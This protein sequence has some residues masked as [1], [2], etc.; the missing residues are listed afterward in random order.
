MTFIDRFSRAVHSARQGV[1]NVEAYITIMTVLIILMGTAGLVLEGT[2]GVL[3]LLGFFFGAPFMTAFVGLLLHL[4]L[5]F[6][7]DSRG[8]LRRYWRSNT[9]PY[10]PEQK[11][12]LPV[13]DKSVEVSTNRVK[14]YAIRFTFLYSSMFILSL[15]IAVNRPPVIAQIVSSSI[16]DVGLLIF[17]SILEFPM[18]ILD[19]PF[20]SQQ[21]PTPNTEYDAFITFLLFVVPLPYATLLMSNLHHYL[22]L[23]HDRNYWRISDVLFS[24]WSNG[25]SLGSGLTNSQFAII[26][27]DVLSTLFLAL[28]IIVNQSRF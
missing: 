21:L 5:L 26:V 19:Q 10:I 2:N 8:L 15:F 18:I 17:A 4:G 22:Y 1:A 20:I 11:T 25:H 3:S 23:K 7:I 9:P 28:F 14:R 16:I 12:G 27:W 13:V 24:N 6:V